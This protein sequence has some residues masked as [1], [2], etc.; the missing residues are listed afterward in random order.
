MFDGWLILP[1]WPK[2]QKV[3]K[4]DNN[5]KG[6]DSILKSLPDEVFQFI[7]QHGYTYQYIEALGRDIQDPYKPLTSPSDYINLNLNLN[8]NGNGNENMETPPAAQAP[9]AETSIA[10][11][12]PKTDPLYSKIKAAFEKVYGDFSDYAKEGAAIKRII[13]LTKGDEPAVEIMVKT[14]YRLTQTS[15]KFWSEQPF[16][17]SVLSA[18]SIWDRVKLEATKNQEHGKSWERIFAELEAKV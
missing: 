7:I 8:L 16:L 1:N 17:P 2:H 9:K 4:D 3:G 15:S 6:I 12:K 14:F 5:R 11:Q 10:I 13:K 18:G